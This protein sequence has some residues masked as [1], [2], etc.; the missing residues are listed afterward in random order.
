MRAAAAPCRCEIVDSD[1]S[2]GGGAFP[3]ARIPSVAIALADR[4]GA[5]EAQLR[6][7]DPPIVGRLADGRLLLDLRTI[8]PDEDALVAARLAALA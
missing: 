4:T 3:T 5:A 6:A 1:A 2:V 7:G 8:F